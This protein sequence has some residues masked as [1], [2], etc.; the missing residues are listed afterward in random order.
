MKVSRIK[1]ITTGGTIGEMGSPSGD[2]HHLV[3][4]A[5]LSQM[6][7]LEKHFTISTLDLFDLPSHLITF[8]NWMELAK[9]V[10]SALRGGNDGVVVTHGTDT[11]EETAYFLDLVCERSGPIVLTGA[12]RMPELPDADGAS[13]LRNAILLAD[14]PESRFRGVLV[15]MA[16]E[17][18]CAREVTKLHPV[19]FTAFKSPE[20]G[21]IGVVERSQV[22]FYRSCPQH[23]CISVS[24]ISARVEGLKCYA[25]MSSEPLRALIEAGFDGVVI[26][27]FGNGEVP[28]KLMPAIRD[29]CRAGMTVVASTRCSNGRLAL[30]NDKLTQSFL[31]DAK[32][33]LEAG[34]IF[35]DVSGPKARVKLAV[36]LSAGMSPSELRRIFRF[37]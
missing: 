5:L 36:C 7:E 20:F 32:E 15:T 11:L 25:D 8:S 23:E 24:S 9:E 35:S 6:T 27:A 33:L 2:R 1:L 16:G 29:A 14:S 37:K 21:P 13:N 18:H 28:P 17:I 10:D 34:V 19:S 4:E 31:G 30:R 26:E 12:M 3:G 22:I